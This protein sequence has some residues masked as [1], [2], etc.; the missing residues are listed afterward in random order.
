M[1]NKG[2]SF[3]QVLLGFDAKIALHYRNRLKKRLFMVFFIFSFACAFRL[4][5]SFSIYRHCEKRSPLS[6][7]AFRKQQKIL[8]VTISCI[9]SWQNAFL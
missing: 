6:E 1:R 9:S 7:I 3:Q 5:L 8:Y 2:Y 4:R